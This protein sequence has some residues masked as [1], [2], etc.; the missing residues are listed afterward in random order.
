M[1][2][3]RNSALASCEGLVKKEQTCQTP[4]IRAL[5]GL[6]PTCFLTCRFLAFSGKHLALCRGCP[7]PVC[8]CPVNKGPHHPVINSQ[9]IERLSCQGEG[10]D[11]SFS[12]PAL[13]KSQEKG[14]LYFNMN[15]GLIFVIL[16]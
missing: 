9:G 16:S 11:L 3:D 10:E 6:L 13:L 4:E 2:A 8:P 7:V 12:L 15:E 14:K 1:S 5:T